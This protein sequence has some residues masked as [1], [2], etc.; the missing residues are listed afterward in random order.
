[1]GSVRSVAR[2]IAVPPPEEIF[3]GEVVGPA[4]GNKHAAKLVSAGLFGFS[5]GSGS[6][7]WSGSGSGSGGVGCELEERERE[8][9]RDR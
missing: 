1:M 2:V 8:K 5:W 6:G 4:A 7:S 9:Q 3:G